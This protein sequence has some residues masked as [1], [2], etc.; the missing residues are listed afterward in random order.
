MKPTKKNSDPSF[1]TLLGDFAQDLGDDTSAD[2][3]AAF[4]NCETQAFFHRDR[5]DQLDGDRHV[6]AWHDHFFVRWQLDRTG[7]VRGTEVELWTIVVEERGVTAAFVLRQHIDLAGEVVVR[8]DRTWL[9]QNLATL[10]VFT[11]G[12]AQQQADVVARLA[13]VQQLAEHFHAGAGGLHGVL[14]A[15]DFDLFAD[16]DDAALNATGHHGA[17]ARDREHVFDWHQEGAVHSA[18][19]RRDVGVEG[20]GQGHDGLLAHRAGVAVQRHTGRTFDDRQVVAWELVL[21]EQ[22]AHFHFDQLEQLGVVDQVALVQEHDDV[23]HAN[24]TGQQDV[25]AGLRHRAVGG[26]THQDRAV[27]LGGTGDHVLDV[28]GVAWAVDVRVVT[29]R[30]FVLDVRGVDG[31]AACLLFRRRIDL[32]VRFCF[33]AEFLRQDGSDSCGQGGLAVVDVTDGADVDVRLGPFEFTFCHFDLPLKERF[34]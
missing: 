26:R 32:V 25:L 29:V 13:L 28:V 20:F 21:R 5:V 19:W 30:G 16:L 24:L 4:A 6:I 17:A 22:L 27:H 2:G 7:H 18:L 10:H 11:L 23:W 9:G 33:A 15:D 12:A 14:D 1:A 8:L 34:T 31:N 3:T